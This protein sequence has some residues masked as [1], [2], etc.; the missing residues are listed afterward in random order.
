MHEMLH[1]VTVQCP[2]CGEDVETLVDTSAGGQRYVEDCQVCCR[3]MDI[4]VQVDA[5]GALTGVDVA[6]DDE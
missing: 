2:Y 6:R 5:S 3:P 4:H 1:Q